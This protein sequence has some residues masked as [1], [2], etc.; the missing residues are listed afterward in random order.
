MGYPGVE[1]TWEDA[2]DNNWVSYYEIFRNGELIDK[3]AKGTF[4]FDHSVALTSQ[5]SMKC[6][7]WMAMATFPIKL[8]RRDL[9]D[10]NF[11]SG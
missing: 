9:L 7:Q 10:S 4:Y 6:V 5:R 11:S 2:V 8:W 3:V 1:L